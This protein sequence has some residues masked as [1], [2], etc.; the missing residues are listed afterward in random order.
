MKKTNTFINTLICPICGKETKQPVLRRNTI[1]L[2]SQNYDLGSTYQDV[3]P[4]LYNAMI[5][6]ECGYAN[7]I[8][9]FEKPTEKKYAYDNL[10]KGIWKPIEIKEEN[11]IENSIYLHKLVLLNKSTIEKQLYGEIGITCLKL[12]YLNKLRNNYSEMIRFRKLTL[13]SLIKGYETEDFPFVKSYNSSTVCY[14]IGV[15]SYYEGNIEDSKNWI[16]KVIINKE[17]P[18]NLKE[19]ARNFKEEYLSKKV[20]I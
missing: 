11:T 9:L 18:P 12:Y 4:L 13:D 3:E 1:K 16:S 2:I 15:F 10:H 5:C 19:K 14:L 6:N 7:L 17:T 20:S 8:Q